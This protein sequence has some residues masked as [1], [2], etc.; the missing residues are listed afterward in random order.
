MLRIAHTKVEPLLMALCV[1]VDL[2]VEV[3]DLV[4][5][6]FIRAT[7]LNVP[8]AHLL[9]YYFVQIATLEHGVKDEILRASTIAD[10]FLL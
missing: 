5:F 7:P 2:Y 8:F 4:D 9:D 10:T 6:L 3:V 1:R